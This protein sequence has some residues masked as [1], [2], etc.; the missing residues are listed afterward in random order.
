MTEKSIRQET[1]SMGSIEVDATKYWGAQTQRSLEHFSIGVEHFPL[2]MIWALG[3]IKKACAIVNHRNDNLD[4][5]RFKAISHACDEVISGQL[6]SHFPLYVWQTGSGTQT[7]M[8]VNEV[9]ANRA[10]EL[11]G[12]KRGDK[13]LV[14][15][16]DHVNMSQSSNDVF[17]S[18]MNMAALK[19]VQDKL[20]V[21]M[22]EIIECYQKKVAE[23]KEIIKIGRTHLMD[24]TPITLGQEF[25]GHLAQLKAARNSITSTLKEVSELAIGGSAVGTG[26]NTPKNFDSDVTKELSLLSDLKVSS[27]PNKFMALAAND[28][29]V[30]LSGEIKR[31]STVL[32]KIANDVRW[33]G[34]GP[35]SGLGELVLPAN[36]PGSSIMPG[37][38]NPTQCEALTMV[39]LQVIG[40]DTTVAMAGASGNFEL[41]VYRPVIIYNVLQS[42]ELISA[43]T[44][45]FV[46]YCLKDLQADQKQIKK[47]LENSLML[48]TA[49]APHIGY[50]KA[51]QVAKKAHQEGLTLKESAVMLGVLE[52]EEYEKLIDPAKMIGNS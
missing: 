30:S 21:A 7:N 27:A 14:H 5:R 22:D 11:L 24:A 38:V 31:L 39:C 43:S 15:P 48:V 46:K 20:L 2:E 26:L 35:R 12:G 8:N 29:L 1:D 32:F 9:I 17:P 40:N 4:D 33:L 45:N 51:A 49:L 10:C 41:N 42:I 6:T 34:S 44:Q 36:E 52:K 16:N 19:M 50:D 3:L 25:S 37:K 13:N 28:A 23:Y 18:A 47:H